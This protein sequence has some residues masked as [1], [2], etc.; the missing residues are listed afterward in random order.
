MHRSFRL[1][2]LLT[3]FVVLSTSCFDAGHSPTGIERVR[4]AGRPGTAALS[5]LTV[6][7]AAR[8]TPLTED[9]SW[10]FEAGPAG[11]IS[12][13]EAV[14]LTITIPDGA[15]SST[16]TITVT[17]LAGSAAAYRFV[18]HLVFDSPVR[19]TQDM[20]LLGLLSPLGLAGAHFEGDALQFINGLAIVT[21]LVPAQISL[22]RRTV[23][24]DVTHFS[25]WIVA[26][27]EGP[28]PR[29]SSSTSEQ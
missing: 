19:L 2:A 27:N 18:P 20:S 9:V 24:I 5:L 1:P 15:L 3:G 13:N 26:G 12:R 11:A 28:P 14:G 21:E 16:Q 29:D 22:L 10:T 6:I 8:T 4:A 23:S 7:P 25:G 17:A